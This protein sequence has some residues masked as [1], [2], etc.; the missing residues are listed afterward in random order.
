VILCC[1]LSLL[2][3]A[4]L[5]KLRQDD[6]DTLSDLADFLRYDLLIAAV[7]TLGRSLRSAIRVQSVG[8]SSTARKFVCSE[9]SLG[10]TKFAC[11][12]PQRAAATSTD[13]K[14]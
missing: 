13:G 3:H 1:F 7:A 9:C 14:H 8:L 12:E 2:V 5:H 6:A 11:N 4:V 10:T